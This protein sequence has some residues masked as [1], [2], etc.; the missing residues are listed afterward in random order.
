[1]F[2]QRV[3]EKTNTQSIN[4]LTSIKTLLKP[5]DFN[6]DKKSSRLI[7]ELIS[8][9]KGLL[10]SLNITQLNKFIYNRI[11]SKTTSTMNLK[12]SC[13]ISTMRNHCMSG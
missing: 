3:N 12:F 2:K 11:N 13:Y 1:M 5:D 9:T 10:L 4:V 6:R 8:K 7:R